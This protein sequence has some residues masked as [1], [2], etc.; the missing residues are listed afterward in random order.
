MHDVDSPIRRP[1]V[2]L[3][4]TVLMMAAVAALGARQAAA[5]AKPKPAAA[6]PAAMPAPQG[7]S[8][9]LAIVRV[10][11]GS[12]DDYVALQKSDNMPALQKGG[13]ASRQAWRSSSG[14]GRPY[15]V[16]FLYPVKSW[17]EMDDVPPIRK[18]LGADGEKALNAKM[19]PLIDDVRSF[20]MR[21]RPDLGFVSDQN[22]RPTM[23]IL[24]HIQV[25]P[26]KQASF[27]SLLKTEWAPLLKKA[28]VP[29]YGVYEVT[30]GGNLGEFYTFTPIDKFAALDGGHPIMKVVTPAQ[31]DLLST[32]IGAVVS[33]VERTI[34]KLDEDLSF[35]SM[36]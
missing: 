21:S 3:V 30:L 5:P 26:G 16:A 9:Y 23:G 29:L 19:R 25:A 10:K 1:L 4:A 20:A 22:A 17:A 27:E 2:A 28:G 14:F 24:A 6:A 18:A 33:S 8:I 32:K 7:E 11:P 34:T 13:R 31:F 12:W 15:E 36:Q 35:G